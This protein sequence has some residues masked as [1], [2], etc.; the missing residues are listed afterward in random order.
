MRMMTIM[1][2]VMMVMVGRMNGG[3]I[4]KAAGDFTEAAYCSQM[5][6]SN[7]QNISAARLRGCSTQWLWTGLSGWPSWWSILS[8]F[9]LINWV[10]D[11]IGTTARKAW[12]KKTSRQRLPRSR[13]NQ[14]LPK[15]RRALYLLGGIL[16]I[17]IKIGSKWKKTS[18]NGWKPGV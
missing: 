11:R 18:K 7:M 15:R 14:T 16:S 1:V 10:N 12:R 8:F 5:K 6:P 17:I 4:E 9:Q 13:G 2:M 3:E